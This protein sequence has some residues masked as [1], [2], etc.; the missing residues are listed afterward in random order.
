[1]HVTV[2]IAAAILAILAIASLVFSNCRL[3]GSSGRAEKRAKR[4]QRRAKRAKCRQCQRECKA[5]C[6]GGR[7]GRRCK[8]RCK[9]TCR[10]N[11][12]AT[13]A[14]REVSQQPEPH[15]ISTPEDVLKKQP[16][17]H[18]ISTPEDVLKKQIL[19]IHDANEA[20]QTGKE[21][22]TGWDH[23]HLMMK[24]DYFTLKSYYDGPILIRNQAIQFNEYGD[25]MDS[26]ETVR[27]DIQIADMYLSYTGV[28]IYGVSL[29]PSMRYVVNAYLAKIGH[30]R[31]PDYMWEPADVI[32][33]EYLTDEE[34]KRIIY[35]E[36]MEEIYNRFIND[37]KPHHTYTNPD[38]E[39]SM[40]TLYSRGIIAGISSYSFEEKKGF[41]RTGDMSREEMI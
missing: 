11:D 15:I 32:R 40:K 5:A 34:L 38:L 7:A 28:T 3:T 22:E 18:I 25:L 41:A 9:R 23:L 13:N 37:D 20:K 33:N 14:A 2:I 39:I 27:D 8:R 36:V 26:H 29:I 17:P 10:R 1:M 19:A 21:K 35:S 4:A 6:G 24:D 16:E 12:C 30:D 31:M